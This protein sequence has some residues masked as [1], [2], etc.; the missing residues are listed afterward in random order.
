MT[1]PYLL[2][3]ATLVPL[4]SFLVL[5]FFGRKLGKVSAYVATAAIVGSCGLSVT[6]LINALSQASLGTEGRIGVQALTYDWIPLGGGQALQVGLMVDALTLAMF[7][8]VTIVASLVHIFSIG[9][10]DGDKRFSR[11]FAYLGL[12]CFSMLGL[13]LSNSL[14]QLFVFWELVGVC[15][16]LLIGFWF[17]KRGP[18]MA[19]KKA[20][21]TN[22]IGDAGFLIGLGL[23]MM[24]VGPASFTLYS[25]SN[26]VMA[27]EVA[28][29]MGAGPEVFLQAAPEGT[30]GFLGWSWLTW[31]GLALFAGAVAKSAQFPL[32]VWL[33]DAM[34][35]PT[36]VSALIHAATMVAAGVYLVARIYPILTL[37]ARL[38]VA[39]V[40]CTTL[41]MGALIALVMTD[42]KKILAYSTIS[43]LGFMILFMGMG[44]YV[45]GLFHLITHAFF[46]ACLFLGSGSVI[47]AC[48]HEQE[49]TKMGGLWRKIPITALTFAVSV[50]AI[51]GT[52]YF[53]GYYSK[54]LGLAAAYEA[55]EALAGQ[56][57]AY[58]LLFWIP[59]GVAYLTAFYMWRCWWLT[60][61]GKP[62]DQHIYDH[63]KESPVM[64]LPLIVLGV[65]AVVAGYKWFG[66][67]LLIDASKAAAPDMLANT[68]GE[69]GFHAVHQYV[70][71]A[72]P[73]G[74]LLAV[75][76]YW[77][78][79]GVA[80]RIRRVPGVNLVY[81]WLKNKMF[82]DY[83]YDG[84]V[85]GVCKLAA[86]LAAAFD[87]YVVDGLVNLG[88]YVTRLV[89]WVSGLID[90]YFVDGLVNGAA[91]AAQAAGR[92]LMAPQTGRVRLYV[93]S[94]VTVVAVALVGLTVYLMVWV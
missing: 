56:N 4:A 19:S 64:T 68:P 22:R 90:T 87:K 41:T 3:I 40:G 42:I 84:V 75:A 86:V 83:L 30:A 24:H 5:I 72:W 62:R 12:F 38:V 78:G 71:F 10:M 8:M 88:G 25:G 33:P 81:I 46:K 37:D 20:M 11:F 58:M 57:E 77:N 50:L 45:A 79:F 94:T 34:E 13:V 44:A 76:I 17:E 70:A 73:A 74:L 67:E 9:Y 7:V 14:L 93:L 2:L 32:H 65:L 55:A 31:A 82:F 27:T 54:D 29:A 23:L 80:D 26:P 61:G 35:G 28:H 48:H 52:P 43:Q 36:P 51:A 69:H 21:I 18:A 89:A 16:Y 1:A 92:G 63:A 59:T 47:A 6:A 66:I 85:V 39:L 60:F 53:S 91:V 49:V 15:S